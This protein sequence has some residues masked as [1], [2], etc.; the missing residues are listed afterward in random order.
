MQTP[1]D[2]IPI[3]IM[4]QRKPINVRPLT[5]PVSAPTSAV[6]LRLLR[7]WRVVH[8]LLL[9]RLRLQH[10]LALLT[11][12]DLLIL[13]CKIAHRA[14]ACAHAV[15]ATIALEVVLCSDVA[16]VHHGKE[17]VDAEA[18]KTHEGHALGNR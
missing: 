9:A 6:G 3:P 4:T 12:C 11:E 1:F 14:A 8:A 15:T 17:E 10:R 7:L 16:S 2:P 18:P 5:Q 13:L